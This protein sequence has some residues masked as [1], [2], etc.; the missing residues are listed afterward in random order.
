MKPQWYDLLMRPDSDLR[1]FGLPARRIAE[2]REEQT[3]HRRSLIPKW[4]R[5]IGFWGCI[6]TQ[7]EIEAITGA[8]QKA[9][10]RFAENW[11]LRF[12]GRYGRISQFQLAVKVYEFYQDTVDDQ[13]EYDPIEAARAHYILPIEAILY[14]LAIQGFCTDREMDLWE[15]IENFAKPEEQWL[16]AE[17]VIGLPKKVMFSIGGGDDRLAKRIHRRCG[18]NPTTELRRAS[19]SSPPSS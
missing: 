15:L 5:S 7:V 2:I 8:T 18:R 9:T 1:R 11:G 14:P 6:A 17:W 13:R 19:R 12:A 16:S 10:R 3:G 4:C